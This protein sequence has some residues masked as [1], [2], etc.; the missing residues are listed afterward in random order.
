MIRL[1]S[2]F[3]NNIG[4]LQYQVGNQNMGA[5]SGHHLLS[6]YRRVGIVLFC[7][8]QNNYKY[9]WV[10]T[11]LLKRGNDKHFQSGT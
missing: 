10:K 8:E 7:K 2:T 5:S 11:N 9:F 4:L 6:L 1:F 3:S